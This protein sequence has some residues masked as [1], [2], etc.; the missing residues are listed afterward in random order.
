MKMKGLE[1]RGRRMKVLW[2]SGSGV[3]GGSDHGC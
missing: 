1:V 2:A 3:A